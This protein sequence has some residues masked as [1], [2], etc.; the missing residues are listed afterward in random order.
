VERMFQ[1]GIE[2]G[3]VISD[4][5]GP[6]RRLSDHD[7]CM[8]PKQRTSVIG[9]DNR[10]AIPEVG[11]HPPET[12]RAR[13]S[14]RQNVAGRGQNVNKHNEVLTAA[15]QKDWHHAC[16]GRDSWAH[17]DRRLSQ[18]RERGG[19]GLLKDEC[20]SFP[21]ASE[22][23]ARMDDPTPRSKKDRETECAFRGA[24]VPKQEPPF[25]FPRGFASLRQRL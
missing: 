5:T 7:T 23:E 10:A 24:L 9:D 12:E 19:R 13:R 2:G 15:R 14:V 1:K 21:P 22:R 6:K 20:R 17:S 8:K 4:E 18:V 3:E 11:E 25:Y 16:T